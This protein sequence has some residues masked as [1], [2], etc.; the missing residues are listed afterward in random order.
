M[1]KYLM[2]AILMLIPLAFAQQ[3]IAIGRPS[4]MPIPGGDLTLSQNH[5]YSVNFDGEGEATVA[6]KVAIQNTGK[7]LLKEVKLEIPGTSVRLINALQEV[8]TKKQR[9][10]NWRDSPAPYSKET[11]WEDLPEEQ[12]NKCDY[13]YDQYEIKYYSL[14]RE[15]NKLSKSTQYTF[16]LPKPI[17]D[18]ETAKIILYYKAEGY[19]DESA[20]VFKFDFE[21]LKI[22]QDIN[23]I[24]VSV[25]VQDDLFLEGVESEV[26]YRGGAM[27]EM[28]ESAMAPSPSGVA[29]DALQ[30]FSNQIEWAPGLVKEAKGLDPLESFHVT[31]RYA[32]SRMALYQGK[33][34]ISAIVLLIAIVGMIFG[35]RSLLRRK[36]SSSSPT[37]GVVGGGVMSAVGIFV[38]WVIAFIL[39]A[40]MRQI[41]DY[42]MQSMVGLLIMLI[43]VLLSLAL[44]IGTPILVGYR[45]GIPSGLMTVGVMMLTLLVLTIIAVVFLIAMGT[46]P[47]RG[48]IIMY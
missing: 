43:S 5:F 12:R 45:Y 23:Q 34:W 47:G 9:C 38:V 35:A 31:G 1:K 15:E 16:T 30:Q 42:Q 10:S 40:A 36:T 7:E 13:W 8:Q 11:S 3:D 44:L 18:Q 20:G 32:K 37:L 24:R 19:T 28:A 6:A 22:N 14:E 21:T 48:P 4:I 33:I 46:N 26:E 29:S 17:G 2:L 27:L 25:T 41:V 39:I